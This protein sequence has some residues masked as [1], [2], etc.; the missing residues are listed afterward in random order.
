VLGAG[1]QAGDTVTGGGAAANDAGAEAGAGSSRRW[2]M[3]VAG[4]RLW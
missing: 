4:K 1:I 2:S 3:R